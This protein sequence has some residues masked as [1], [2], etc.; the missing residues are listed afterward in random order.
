MRSLIAKII[1]SPLLLW[2]SGNLFDQLEF[3]NVSHVILL[4]LLLAAVGTLTDLI[5]LHPGT[6]WIATVLD[7]LVYTMMIYAITPWLNGA[8][9][10]FISALSAGL[11]F[12]FAEY[13]LHR[14]LI[15]H[16]LKE[17]READES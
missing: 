3:G 9:A 2:L 4:G 11:L 1:I 16:E 5:F 7:W 15:L 17:R 10:S 8:G 13:A 14:Y 12:A 6:L